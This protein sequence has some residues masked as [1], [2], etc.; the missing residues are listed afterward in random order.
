[1]PYTN[2]AKQ[3]LLLKQ[4]QSDLVGQLEKRNLDALLKKLKIRRLGFESHDLS[5]FDSK[6][7][8]QNLKSVKFFEVDHLIEAI[9]SVKDDLEVSYIQRASTIAD[10]AFK[11]IKTFIKPGLKEIEVAWELEKYMREQ[12]AGGVA[13]SPFIVAA[14]KNSS[15]AH[16]GAG[17]TKIRNGDMVQLDFGCSYRGYVC[18]ISRV[19]FVGKPTEKQKSIYEMVLKAQQL[20]LS[21]VK[22][23]E[24]GGVI[25]KKVQEFL[26]KQTKHYYKHSLGHGVGLDV[27][28][29]PYVSAS[30]KNKL[31]AGN[32]I[33][34]EPGVYISGWGGVRIEDT[35]LVT[36]EGYKP[37]TKAPKGIT[38]TTI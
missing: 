17:E 12:G 10:K 22:E 26:K 24:N 35:V 34:I 37:L 8:K 27:H 19:L 21:L 16:W 9:R 7:I 20:G 23:G 5:V 29:A 25:D 2:L 15:M 32:V 33:T 36:N 4:R 14:G 31:E 1:M 30:R 13:W 6:R 38:K 28:E 11:H 3:R 18:D